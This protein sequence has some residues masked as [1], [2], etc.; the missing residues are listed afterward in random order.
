MRE[1]NRLLNM[2]WAAGLAAVSFPLAAG[3]GWLLWTAAAAT[4]SPAAPG[5]G[6]AVGGAALVY[7]TAIALTPNRRLRTALWLIGAAAAASA[8]LLSPHGI[9]NIAAAIS[10]GAAP[11]GG[12]PF[13]GPSAASAAAT[14]LIVATGHAALT[15][16]AATLAG[17]V[18]SRSAFRGQA[19]FLIGLFAV[20]AFPTMV[21]LAPQFLLL[22][23]LSLVDAPGGAIL[24]LSALELPFAILFMKAAFDRTP[25]ELE[26][27]A[28]ADGASRAEAFR[29]A[30]LPLAAPAAVAVAVLSFMVGW[31]DY[32]VA[33]IVF[34]SQENWT[35]SM[36]VHRLA[37][38][39]LGVDYGALAAL[40]LVYALPSLFCLAIGRHVV[41]RSGAWTRLFE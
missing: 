17:Y 35:F 20:Q 29:D 27:S 33:Q 38:E 19:I 1:T 6:F 10:S 31:G 11:A 2:A 14:G 28:L 37:D 13:N 40:S 5:P 18:C 24:V 15:T 9:E 25:V 21:L 8:F 34:V 36:Y 22:H 12:R 7:A 3:V 26:L 30:A 4:M 41:M 39:N 16:A 23:Q 32:V